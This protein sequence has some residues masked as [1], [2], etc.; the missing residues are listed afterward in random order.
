MDSKVTQ[1]YFVSSDITVS[2]GQNREGILKIILGTEGCLMG[3]H[4]VT[5]CHTG[6]VVRMRMNDC[7]SK[8]KSTG[9][10]AER[11]DMV[12]YGRI[13]DS[14]RSLPQERGLLGSS[15]LKALGHFSHALSEHLIFP[16]GEKEGE[17]RRHRLW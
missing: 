8:A 2:Q 14:S 13:C 16:P 3:S 17:L 1:G 6:A 15:E 12:P 5:Q 9:A 11:A 10:P 4:S 7:C